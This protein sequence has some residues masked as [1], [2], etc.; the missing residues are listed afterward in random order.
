M[1]KELKSNSVP[2]L[3]SPNGL[4][5]DYRVMQSDGNTFGGDVVLKSFNIAS[6]YEYEDSILEQMYEKQIFSDFFYEDFIFLKWVMHIWSNTA[7]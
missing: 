2:N 5:R 3:T 4:G 6:S 1:K 7:L